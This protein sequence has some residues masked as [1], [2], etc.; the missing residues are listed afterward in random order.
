MNLSLQ[1]I[2]KRFGAVTAVDGMSLEI[3]AGE[4]FFLLGPSGSKG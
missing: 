4:C 1:S 2:T 3:S